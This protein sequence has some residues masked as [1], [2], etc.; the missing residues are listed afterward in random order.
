MSG[1]AFRDDGVFRI[2]V[3]E[4]R[5][6]KRNRERVRWR[7][8]SYYSG[9]RAGTE[10]RTHFSK[11]EDAEKCAALLWQDYLQGLH[12][13]PDERP[14]TVK[15]LI[16]R[17]CAR[18]TGK[19]GKMLSSNSTERSYPSQLQSLIRVAGA[20]TP[21]EHLSKKHVEAIKRLVNLRT[22]KP[23]S[24]MTVAAYLRATSALS[25]W[26]TT[27]GYLAADISAQV[28][29][30]KGPIVMRPWLQPHEIELFL[31]DC[32]PS[33]RIRAGLL[34]ETGLRAGEAVH[35]RWSWVQRGIGRPSIRV[36]A[37]DPVT[38]FMA[39]GKRSRHVSL[40]RRAQT[41]LADAEVKWGKDGFVLH[42]EDTPIDSSNWCDDTHTACNRAGVTDVDTHGLRRTAA[43]L[44]FASGMDIFTV[45]RQLGHASVT[46][47]ENAY[48]GI[49]RGHLDAAMDLV[50]ARAA[51][52]RGAPSVAQVDPRSRGT[53]S[54]RKAK[55]A[56]TAAQS[57][58]RRPP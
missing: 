20:D 49:P 50:D 44:W 21:V 35:M 9:H 37:F 52:F 48:S 32:S 57:R 16:D 53:K 17:F 1:H 51:E 58:R 42:G 54:N 22:G 23:L 45:S 12:A 30:D 46:T 3:Y 38:G 15:E 31:A 4:I 27:Q 5:D 18:E 10:T 25:S 41:L 19:S 33:H 55:D 28:Q 14:A 6:A 26:A 34:I 56:P 43:T 47:T 11:V 24:R 36:P 8:Q 29:W 39:K 2:L 7:V 40:S 13:K